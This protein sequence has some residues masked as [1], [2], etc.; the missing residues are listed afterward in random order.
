MNLKKAIIEFIRKPM[1][2]FIRWRR[3]ILILSFVVLISVELVEGS[4]DPMHNIEI[5]V[6]FI[7]FLVIASLIELLLRE[8]RLQNRASQILDYKHQISREFFTLENWDVF[9]ACL[10][11]KLGRL[12]SVNFA[13]LFI[14]DSI[15]GEY[16]SISRWQD[17]DDLANLD[18][19]PLCLDCLKRMQEGKVGFDSCNCPTGDLISPDLKEYFLPVYS[20]QAIFAVVRFVPGPGRDIKAEQTKILKHLG[21]EVAIALISA[22]DRK[23]LS[24]LQVTQA[25]LAERHSVSQY[26]H[27][28]LSQNIG[29][30]RMK[31]E[32][33]STDPSLL[34]QETLNQDIIHMKEVADESYLIV[35]RKLESIH[36]ETMPSLPNYL[37][38]HA[39]KMS[40]RAGFD[41][42]LAVKGNP[43]VIPMD[44]QRAVF[45]VFQEILSNVEKHAQA[46]KVDADLIWGPETLILT[47]SDNGIGFDPSLVTQQQHFGL[48]IVRERIENVNGDLEISSS[49]GTCTQVKVTIPIP[50]AKKGE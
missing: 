38:A 32:R 40:L 3:P 17:I 46:S 9:T 19:N 39:Q 24:E 36:S 35:R 28:N 10:T 41:F 6:Y 33:F 25:I 5:F 30:L 21:D 11:E 43:R 18:T 31:L 47:V 20:G 44:A 23:R 15:S 45:Y 34:Q 42:S 14:R 50:A 29:Y 8:N 48:G 13:E 12:A 49:A 7:L 22:Q 1:G 16:S 26:L 27:D 37:R 4:H 2:W